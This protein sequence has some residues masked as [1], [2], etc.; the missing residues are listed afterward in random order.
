MTACCSLKEHCGLLFNI[1]D[2]I[3]SEDGVVVNPFH[4][5][6]WGENFA[7]METSSCRDKVVCWSAH[8]WRL[9][10]HLGFIIAFAV[11]HEGPNPKWA[12]IVWSLVITSDKL[13]AFRVIVI[14]SS[15]TDALIRPLN[16]LVI[17]LSASVPSL[18]GLMEDSIYI[19]TFYLNSLS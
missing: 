3:C 8:H 14:S 1:V 19:S 10:N 5:L 18:V 2:T 12:F 15:L 7:V 13:L 16:G 9:D 6:E 17:N 4:D 11:F